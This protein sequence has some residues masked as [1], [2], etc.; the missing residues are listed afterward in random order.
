MAIGT[1]VTVNWSRIGSRCFA[2]VV[3]EPHRRWN[4]PSEGSVLLDHLGFR[5]KATR[6][7]GRPVTGP[8]GFNVLAAAGYENGVL[9]LWH[10]RSALTVLTE[11]WMHFLALSTARPRESSRTGTVGPSTLL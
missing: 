1:R 4:W 11:D 5:V 8:V 3:F 7:D 10:L 9:R 6:E 2:P